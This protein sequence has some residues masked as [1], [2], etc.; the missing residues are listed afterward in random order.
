MGAFAGHSVN[1]EAINSILESVDVPIQL[2]AVYVILNRL[3][4]G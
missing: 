2:G 3:N 1:L 4:S